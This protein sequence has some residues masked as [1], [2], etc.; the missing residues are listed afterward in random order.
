MIEESSSLLEKKITNI[1]RIGKWM[2][3]V[4]CIC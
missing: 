3:S 2:G 1:L 4:V